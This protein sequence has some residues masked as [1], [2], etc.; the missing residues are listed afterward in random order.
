MILMNATG[1][2]MMNEIRRRSNKAYVDQPRQSKSVK[3]LA[4]CW[5]CAEIYFKFLKISTHLYHVNPAS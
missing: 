3:M 2:V 1:E 5:S 4:E